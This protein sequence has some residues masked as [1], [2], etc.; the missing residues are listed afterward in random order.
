MIMIE[1]LY[2]RDIFIFIFLRLLI[3]IIE[4]FDFKNI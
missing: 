2:Y 1:F 3:M 4:D